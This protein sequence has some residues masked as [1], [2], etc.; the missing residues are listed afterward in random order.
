MNN[1]FNFKISDDFIGLFH[2]VYPDGF[3]EHLIKCT[4]ELEKEKV[5]ITRKESENADNHYKNDYAIDGRSHDLFSF[6]D[7]SVK[8]L[9]RD[10]LQKCFD[11][12]TDRFST[13][14]TSGEISSTT[15]KI[16][17]TSP[18]GGYHVWHHEQGAGLFSNRVVVFMVYLNTLEDDSYGE[19][20]F[21]YQ[22]RRIKPTENTIVLWPAS[23]T[24]PHRGNPVYG[25]KSKYIITGWFHYEL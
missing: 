6:N 7:M 22:E 24:H 14:K 18:G 17:K 4:D 23:Y 5:G 25:T 13:L 8:Q 16:Q 21:L 3:C 15:M 11:H 1:N 12:Y 10:G 20:E 9:Y 2:N 19:T